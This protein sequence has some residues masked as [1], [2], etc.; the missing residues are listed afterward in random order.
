[1]IRQ[2][3]C[4]QEMPYFTPPA[5]LGKLV[6]P[7]SVFAFPRADLEKSCDCKCMRT[8]C[9]AFVLT[10]RI[11]G[12]VRALN[13]TAFM[14]RPGFSRQELRLV[15]TCNDN[16]STLMAAA[17]GLMAKGPLA[18]ARCTPKAR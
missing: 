5:A 8:R 1:M 12:T 3:L 14:V 4:E 11:F 10:T 6:F 18:A 16:A 15:L 2:C 9:S 13:V 17:A 7:G